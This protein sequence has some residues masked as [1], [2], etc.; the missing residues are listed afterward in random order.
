MITAAL[1]SVFKDTYTGS[2]AVMSAEN[3]RVVQTIEAKY[4]LPLYT[5]PA[6]SL[7]QLYSVETL[8]VTTPDR[9]RLLRAKGA[10]RISAVQKFGETDTKVIFHTE[11]G[12]QIQVWDGKAY[13][14]RQGSDEKDE[15]C[16]ADVSCSAF[17]VDDL[18][19][20]EQ[21]IEK[22]Q[23]ALADE[24]LEL[25][26]GANSLRRR[27]AAYK[28][29]KEK[30]GEEMG[31]R[32]SHE[33]GQLD[34]D[35]VDDQLYQPRPPPS[36]G[37][38]YVLVG[39]NYVLA[40]P[41]PPLAAGNPPQTPPPPPEPAD[42]PEPPASP[43]P[44]APPVT[45]PPEI[46]TAVT[47]GAPGSTTAT[48]FAAELNNVIAVR[49]ND[50]AFAAIT[51]D[52]RV[53]AWGDAASGGDIHPETE[54]G[55]L[56]VDRISATDK[57]F[58]A[59][60]LDKAV[61]AW[62]HPAYGG[63]ASQ[64]A[65]H[66][67]HSVKSV[68]GNDVAFAA[69]KETGDVVAWG[70][71]GAGGVVA[72]ETQVQILEGG[73]AKSIYHT[74]FAFSAVLQNDKVLAWGDAGYG[75]SIPAEASARMTGTDGNPVFAIKNTGAAFAAL[76]ADGQ[77]TAWGDELSG[78]NADYPTAGT[79]ESLLEAGVE[80]L[81]STKYAFLAKLGAGIPGQVNSVRA[82]GDPMG[83]GT[84]PETYALLI[85]NEGGVIQVASTMQAFAV[86]TASGKVFAWGDRHFGGEIK[87]SSWPGSDVNDDGTASGFPADGQIVE[88]ISNVV[89]LYST[90]YAFAARL[91]NSRVVTWGDTN[92][93]GL[94]PS[95]KQA[96][97]QNIESIYANEVAFA[98]LKADGSVVTWG[99]DDAGGDSTAVKSELVNVQ[100]IIT[101]G[102]AFTAMCRNVPG[103]I[104]SMG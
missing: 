84:L 37:N 88:T 90:Q 10:Y 3:G 13:F 19:A 50:F 43:P 76:H 29:G 93:G 7:E 42:P 81:Y 11:T 71:A 32:L 95:H 36:P 62:G 61:V 16:A 75:G 65:V 48:E 87:I 2:D 98:A 30:Y 46:L 18:K 31:R 89:A 54:A 80:M 38:Q 56:E 52:R 28:E 22:A 25:S 53:V 82:W 101:T 24:G 34:C 57:A 85:G 23:K 70:A 8:T 35:L 68:H 103:Q 91:E 15:V 6:L 97:L 45:P 72:D 17:L 47:W 64:V 4:P 51:A 73:G 96:L 20:Q 14:Q 59:L 86:L 99:D 92:T 21:I 77:V 69:I 94:I 79:K 60:R 67:A 102:S 5:A 44:P 26:H 100:S 33:A 39:D 74:Q 66:L 83:G 104:E 58:A 49:A 55:L 41:P 63:D 40:R 27:L 9:A 1:L 12:D 78:G